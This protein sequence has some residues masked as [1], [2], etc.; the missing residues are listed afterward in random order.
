M[1][2]QRSEHKSSNDKHISM[3]KKLTFNQDL[4]LQDR[5]ENAYEFLKIN[6]DRED[7]NK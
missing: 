4:N 5:E 6:Q 3:H 7:D 1:K 2:A